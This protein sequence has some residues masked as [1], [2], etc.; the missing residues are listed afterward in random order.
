M[1]LIYDIVSMGNWFLTNQGNMDVSSS[2]VDLYVLTTEGE[3][4]TTL[5]TWL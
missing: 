5:S 3:E 1:F 2:M 4:T